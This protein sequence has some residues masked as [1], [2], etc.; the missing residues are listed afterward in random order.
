[1]VPVTEAVDRLKSNG[2]VKEHPTGGH[3]VESSPRDS[4]HFTLPTVLKKRPLELWT[5]EDRLWL[6]A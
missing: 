1:M 3:I 6:N 5:E 4:I 2:I